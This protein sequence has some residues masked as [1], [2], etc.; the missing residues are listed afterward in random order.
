MPLDAE[1]I[2][3]FEKKYHPG[4]LT[5][6]GCQSTITP[7]EARIINHNVV[8]EECRILMSETSFYRPDN[9]S[10]STISASPTVFGSP[11]VSAE[12]NF[13]DDHNVNS[14]EKQNRY[15][16]GDRLRSTSSEA[17]GVEEISEQEAAEE[18]AREEKL[19]LEE[20]EQSRKRMELLMS[21]VDHGIEGNLSF[22]VRENK[23]RKQAL[24][25]E[26]TAR[27]LGMTDDEK[28]KVNI[29]DK[30]KR[31]FGIGEPDTIISGDS[32]ASPC[33]LGELLVRF[34]NS[35]GK[36][37]REGQKYNIE[38][39]KIA[40]VRKVSIV[41]AKSDASESVRFVLYCYSWN[42]NPTFD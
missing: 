14:G 19:D 30:A 7:E 15:N 24:S 21:N 20:Q 41:S 11:V 31:L 25:R 5:C 10:I 3:A 36:V 13:D 38:A 8:C 2:L 39:A 35:L 1:V 29:S 40:S 4:C 18:K 22:E 34:K 16:Q 17:F 12:D 32:A 42:I 28:I 37:D 6:A 9:R 23:F 33:P 26:K 27:L